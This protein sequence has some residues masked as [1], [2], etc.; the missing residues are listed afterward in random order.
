MMFA[1]K[2][3]LIYVNACVIFDAEIFLRF[4][5]VMAASDAPLVTSYKMYNA[6]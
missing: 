6:F 1:A 3:S 4:F 5:S 2:G